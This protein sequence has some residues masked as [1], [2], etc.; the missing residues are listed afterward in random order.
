MPPLAGQEQ[1]EGFCCYAT[2]EPP[3][4]QEI[5]RDNNNNS[6]NMNM[7]QSLPSSHTMPPSKRVQQQQQDEDV[8]RVFGCVEVKALEDSEGRLQPHIIIVLPP[9]GRRAAGSSRSSASFSSM[10]TPTTREGSEQQQWNKI[11]EVAQ[12]A[13]TKGGQREIQVEESILDELSS[14]FESWLG[15]RFV[16]DLGVGGCPTMGHEGKDDDDDGNKMQPLKSALRKTN[17][18]EGIPRNVSFTSLKIREFNMTLG[19]HPSASS[20]PPVMLD[21]NSQPQERVIDLDMYERGRQPRRNRKELK[22]S[23][24]DR[25]GILEKERGFSVE[26]VKEAWT[27]ALMIRKQ[28]QETRQ[29]GPGMMMLDEFWESAGRKYR[30][31]LE[32][33]L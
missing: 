14:M 12:I 6:D 28:R 27:E 19:N 9:T 17:A 31:M 11:Q 3:Q 5:I 23:F 33:D 2:P 1:G 26:E 24:E 13:T 4:Q 16:E 18:G 30:R 21:W 20:G 22:L 7:D 10:S 29:Q 25:R 32:F 15:C 8:M